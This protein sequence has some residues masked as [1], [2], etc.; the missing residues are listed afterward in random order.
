MFQLRD[1]QLEQYQQIVNSMKRG[2]H[3]IMVQSPP[4]TGKTVL[5]AEIARKTTANGGR[6][7]FIVH[8]KEIVEQ[9]IQTFE[10]QSVDMSLAKIGMVQTFA[11]HLD[12]LSEPAVL[13]IDEAHHALAKSYRRVI[14]Y[15]PDA[16]KLLFTGTPYRLNGKGFREVAE[17]LIVGKQINWLIQNGNL[18]PIDYYAPKQIDTSELRTKRGEFTEESIANAT[19]PKIYGNAVKT[20]EKLATGKQAIAYTYNVESAQRLAEAF[21]EAGIS[22]RA[23]SAKT[24]K[25]EREKII[26][27]YRKGDIKVVANAML[28]TEGLDLP[29]VDCV[30]MLRPTQSLAL[31]LQF[32]MRSMNPRPGKRAIIIDHVGNVER[33]GLPSDDRIW[34]L[35]DAKK[36]QSNSAKSD[37]KPVTVCEQCFGT[38]YRT[39][40]TCPYCGAIIPV[41][42]RQI[43]VD[44]KVELQKVETNKRLARAQKIIE[45]NAAMSVADKTPRQLNSMAELKAY[46]ELHNYKRGWIY[47]Q[48]KQ[49]GLIH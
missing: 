7:M 21:N 27:Q 43:E 9:V 8:R 46:A 10:A 5:M 17:D 36:G 37:I 4:R 28:Y 24:P 45:S 31:F 41:K 19:K 20:Y 47:Y 11:R 3:S 1:Y 34:T 38:F 25:D 32:G 49:K 26:S 18:A 39:G 35:D 22:A 14:D 48:A 30:I 33:F 40:D 2:H 23:V 13:F 44:E 6:V 42:E 29:N 12:E 15:Y 16:V